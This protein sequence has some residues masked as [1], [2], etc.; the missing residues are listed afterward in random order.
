MFYNE[1]SM[2]NFNCILFF[3]FFISLNTFSQESSLKK[4]FKLDVL[5]KVP[6]Y[7]GCK[8]SNEELHECFSKSF[9]NFFSR[10][11]DSYLP[12]S[13][14]L[15][16][17]RKNIIINFKINNKGL[18]DS[19]KV[20]APHLKIEKEIIRVIKKLP[21]MIPGEQNGKIVGVKYSIPITIF[22]DESKKERREKRIEKR[23]ARKNK[24]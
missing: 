16:S 1:H 4:D 3:L 21:K 22:I 6:I 24:N 23:K 7:P 19:I 17:G 12:N 8:G 15:P 2:R 14:G 20:Y 18:S 5:E 9:K 10:K 11:F 13:L